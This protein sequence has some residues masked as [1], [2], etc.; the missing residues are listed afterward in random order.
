MNQY[1]TGQRY[2]SLAEPELGLGIVNQTEGR[3]VTIDYPLTEDARLYSTDSASL[4]RC[5]FNVGDTIESLSGESI[6]IVS[7]EETNSVITYFSPDGQALCE[8]SV[9]PMEGKVSALDRLKAGQIGSTKWFNLYRQL[10]EAYTEFQGS[11]SYGFVGPKI[12]IIPHQ[13]DVAQQ[14]LNMPLPRALLADEVGLGKTIEAG[15][16]IHQLIA[17]GRAK[18]ILICTPASLVN[19]WLVEMKRKFNLDCTLVDDE[20]CAEQQGQNPFNQIQ[21]A[22]CNFD[23]LAHSEFLDQARETDWDMMVIDE[24]HRLQ[25]ESKAYKTALQ[26]SKISSGVLLLTAT[27]E[28]LGVESHF[29]RLHLLDPLRFPDLDQF[30]GEEQQY[31]LI[32]NLVDIV[33][34]DGLAVCL[35]ELE[36]LNDDKLLA[37]AEDTVENNLDESK[38]VDWMADRYG[39]GRMV[40]RNTR[41]SI[42]G[43]PVRH[44]EFYH[45]KELSNLEWIIDW[46]AQ[47]GDK[48]ILVI[49]KTADLAHEI[50]THIQAITDIQTGAFHEHYTLVERDQIAAQFS[51]EDGLQILV[52]SEIG[53]EGRNFQHAQHLVLFD[54]PAHPDLVDQRIGRLDRI[55][56]GSDIYI[57][58]PVQSKSAEARLAALF[59]HGFDMF[60][61][62]N[63]AASPIFEAYNYEIDDMLET[64]AEAESVIMQCQQASQQLLAEIEDGRDKLLEQHSFSKDRIAPLLDTI[65]QTDSDSYRLE[66]LIMNIFD[67]S[68]IDTERTSNDNFIISPQENCPFSFINSIRDDRCTITFSREQASVREELEFVSWDHPWIK[69]MLDDLEASGNAF[70]SCSMFDNPKLKN[71]QVLVE[72]F[73]QVKAEGPGRLELNRYLAPQTRHY[74]I[75]EELKNLGKQLDL[76]EMRENQER[77]KKDMAA[78]I[79]HLKIGE[80]SNAVSLAEK[81]AAHTSKDQINEAVT[82]LLAATKQELAR[83]KSLEITPGSYQSEIDEL[84]S[85][86]KESVA[87]LQNAKPKLL[88]LCIW[89]NF[90]K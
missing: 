34:T 89:V 27:P 2:I 54:L 19:Q 41:R 32:S 46:V 88:S 63:P 86:A 12:N 73:F 78:Q 24:S 13:F 31:G 3:K 25:F 42:P 18:R 76:A 33:E 66:S 20:F 4:I 30:L 1:K 22:L 39:T 5:K 45:L 48:K 9:S 74:L 6:L 47:Q 85:K 72:S 44:T 62:P 7:S 11:K 8:S 90:K 17:S 37:L 10:T 57:H 40:Y 26:L 36:K 75:S 43:F 52:C 64:G 23:W 87:L 14:I 81:L 77:I 58:I 56:Q 53:G 51:V 83:Y 28:Q 50:S 71:G 29:A 80:I 69:G 15:L 21:V 70:T 84:T 79:T 60:S 49:C 38:F 35:P 68:Y 67:N 82:R 61:Q 59:H 65:K 55:G 16:V